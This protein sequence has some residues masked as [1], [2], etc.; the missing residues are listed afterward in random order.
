MFKRKQARPAV[1]LDQKQHPSP[2]KPVRHA[3]GRKLLTVMILIL[4]SLALIHF[5]AVSHTAYPTLTTVN[6]LD[7]IRNSDYTKFVQVDHR[8]QAMGAVQLVDQL[9]DEQPAALV[10]VEDTG[11]QHLLDVYVYGCTLQQHH[12]T[13]TLLFKQQGLIQ[14]TLAVTGSNTLSIGELD[15]TLSQ[16]NSMLLQPLQQNVYRE[17]S[18]RDNA[19]L[20]TVF[21]GLYPVTSRSEA[22]A[23]Q[24]QANNGQSLPWSD[25]LVTAQQMAKDLFHWSDA[26]TQ[27][28]LQDNNGKTAHV[29]LIQQSPHIEVQVTLARL[30]QPTETGLWFATAAHT[31]G[32][33]LEQPT[34]RLPLISPLSLQGMGALNDGETTATLFDHTLTP[35]HPLNPGAIQVNETGRFSGSLLYTSTISNQP[36]L[37]LI[38]SLPPDGSTEAGQILLTGLILG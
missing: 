12:P 8:T 24:D 15:T 36:G 28:T 5:I 33:T 32:I 25:P 1:V 13:L 29:L 16:E 31:P 30:V 4:A 9:L 22:E 35:I 37:L 19:F 20:Q 10:P 27:T 38:E 23:L 14:G 21:P 6:C 26:T 11:P 17:Y 2:E 18:W 3:R 7:L 34:V